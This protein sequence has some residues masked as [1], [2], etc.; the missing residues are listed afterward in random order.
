MRLQQI[1]D[2]NTAIPTGTG[3]GTTSEAVAKY[4]EIVSSKPHKRMKK[5]SFMKYATSEKECPG[6]ATI[7]S[8]GW[9]EINQA[10]SKSKELV[11]QMCGTTHKKGAK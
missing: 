9:D 8:H 3:P 1:L 6:C 10:P 11:C 7:K 2:E 4:D 5:M